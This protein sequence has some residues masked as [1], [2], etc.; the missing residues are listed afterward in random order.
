MLIY[1]IKVISNTNGCY[2]ATFIV[3]FSHLSINLPWFLRHLVVWFGLRGRFLTH[4]CII[5]WVSPQFVISN[6]NETTKNYEHTHTDTHFCGMCV[7]V[8]V[9]SKHMNTHTYTFLCVFRRCKTVIASCSYI[10]VMLYVPPARSLCPIMRYF[11]CF[12]FQNCGMLILQLLIMPS[13]SFSL[14]QSF[15]VRSFNPLKRRARV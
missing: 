4:K 3:V 9:C 12:F 10:I 1:W 7:W 6:V 2:L 8:C 11:I 5:S 14:T 15:S 13:P